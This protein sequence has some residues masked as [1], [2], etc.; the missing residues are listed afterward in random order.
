MGEHI[1]AGIG[2]FLALVSA[3]AV[4][5]PLPIEVQTVRAGVGIHAVENDTDAMGVGSVAKRREV[6]F[7]TQHRVGGLVVT[8]VVAVAGK[9]LADG[10]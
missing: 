4:E 2:T 5:M 10:I 8:G 3:D 7:R 9:T 1:P 6:R